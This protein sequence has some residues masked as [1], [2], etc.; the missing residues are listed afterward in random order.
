[1][2]ITKFEF[3]FRCDKIKVLVL[4]TD[5]MLTSDVEI[6]ARSSHEFAKKNCLNLQNFDFH[7]IFHNS[8][9]K[10]CVNLQNFDLFMFH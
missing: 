6:D 8:I 3:E 4:V 10:N 5:Q 2:I 9:F 1:M 7:L